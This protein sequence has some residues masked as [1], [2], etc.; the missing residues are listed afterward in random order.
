MFEIA[1]VTLFL[2]IVCVLSAVAM[3]LTDSQT[4]PIIAEQK[5]KAEE[6]ARKE[7]LPGAEKFEAAPGV[8]GVYRGLDASGKLLGFVG[9]AAGRGFG[10]KVFVMAGVDLQGKIT[11]VRVLGHTETPG[12][13]N[14]AADSAGAPI[15]SMKGQT[16][17]A[18]WLAKDRAGQGKVDSITGVTV[19]SRAV[20]A[21]VREILENVKKAGGK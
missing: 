2:M 8:E 1:K 20:T 7:V 3:A 6:A 21:G 4:R 18:M 17:A 14:R 16:A 13:G 15:R 5:R 9:T 19:T 10:G 12:L 11:G